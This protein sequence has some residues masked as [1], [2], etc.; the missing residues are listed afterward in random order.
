LQGRTA[1]RVAQR[2]C[3]R[4]VRT[5]IADRPCHAQAAYKDPA[6]PEL[7]RPAGTREALPGTKV[8]VA[9]SKVL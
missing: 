4:L 6:K 3:F 2:V 7:N 9:R 5:V 8:N 1:K